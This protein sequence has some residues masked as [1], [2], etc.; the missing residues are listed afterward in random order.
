MEIRLHEGEEFIMELIPHPASFLDLYGFFF[1]LVMLGA[2]LIA[3]HPGLPEA[4]QYSFAA[5]AVGVLVPCVWA[6]VTRIRWRWLFFGILLVAASG[7][8]YYQFGPRAVGVPIVAAGL[9][10]IPLTD[11]YRRSHR[12]YVTSERIVM[13]AGLITREVREVRLSRV[14]DVVLIQGLL[15]RIFNFGTIF[16]VTPSALGTGQDLAMLGLRGDVIEIAGGRTVVVPR[17]R[18]SQVLYG[19]T[20]PDEVYSELSR[21]LREREEVTYLKKILEKLDEKS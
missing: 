21:L 4:E 10:G 7:V 5:A 14:V 18:S 3:G 8:A 20:N 6:A 15:G 19:V 2:W 11:A 17:G 9:L 1:Y 16:P 13:R 12:Y